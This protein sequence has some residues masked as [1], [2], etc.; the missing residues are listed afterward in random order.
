[1]VSPGTDEIGHSQL[2]KEGHLKLRFQTLSVK[3]IIN[4]LVIEVYLPNNFLINLLYSLNCLMFSQLEDIFG[5]ENGYA[6]KT[7]DIP[8]PDQVK[9]IKNPVIVRTSLIEYSMYD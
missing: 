2:C 8:V 1:M 7:L 3:K 6:T 4:I 5:P 9:N